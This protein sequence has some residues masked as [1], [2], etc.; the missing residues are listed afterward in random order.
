MFFKIFLFQI[1]IGLFLFQ[2]EGTAKNRQP[3]T[4]KL[5]DQYLNLAGSLV[6]SDL[7]KSK[8]QAAKLAELLAA[9]QSPELKTYSAQ[10]AN[11]TTLSEI[12]T[13][14]SRLST[15]LKTY[16]SN[17]TD[18]EDAIYVA[19]CPMALNDTGAIWLTDEKKVVNPYFGMEMLHCG[20]I[21][22][23]VKSGKP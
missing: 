14:F 16:L 6:K 7:K 3:N 20:K 9:T 18:L 4:Q 19:H 10:V 2:M 17:A 22:G 13:A 12:R 23:T 8:T 11:G 21:I 5:V 15:S 1:F